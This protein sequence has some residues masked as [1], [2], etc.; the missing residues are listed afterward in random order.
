MCVLMHILWQ[1]RRVQCS[2]GEVARAIMSTELLSVVL[3]SLSP[4]VLEV[5]VSLSPVALEALVSFSP[6][7]WRCWFLSVLWL[8]RRW[9]L[10]VMWLWRCWSLSVLSIGSWRRWLLS[11]L[12]SMAVPQEIHN[13]YPPQGGWKLSRVL[14]ATIW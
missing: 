13:N 14:P 2:A 1:S 8:W 3:V 9:L 6:G 4:V 11:V 10:S 12:W 5:Q 7:L